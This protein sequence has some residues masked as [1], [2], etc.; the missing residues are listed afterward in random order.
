MKTIANAGEDPRKQDH[1]PVLFR[2][3]GGESI[4]LG[5]IMRCLAVA[6]ALL[7]QGYPCLFAVTALPAPAHRRLEAA[8]VT[9]VAVPGPPGGGGDR[10][11]T[12]ALAARSDAVV[13]DGYDFDPAYRAAVAAAGR[14][15]LAFDDGAFTGEH[16]P[17]LL[18][19][20]MVV[21]PSVGV[22]PRDYAVSAPGAGL[23]LGASHAPLRRE[24]RQAAALPPRSL[25]DRTAVLLTFG[26]S[27]PLGLTVPCLERLAPALPDGVRLLTVVGGGNPR[28][29]A[30]R[31]AAAAWGNRVE[32][33]HD[34]PVMGALMARSGLAVAAAGGTTAELAALAVPSLLVV[35]ADNQA[36]A[37]TAAGVLPWCRIVDARGGGDAAADRVAEAALTLWHAPAVRAAMAVAAR[38]QVDGEGAGRI[39]QALRD[40]MAAAVVPAGVVPV[41]RTVG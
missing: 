16:P 33:H 5:H 30:C 27:D 20:R 29:D 40:A 28:L 8:G 37:A 38:G 36:P 19:A 14:P 34:T 35:V 31:A 23:L 9:V 25:S 7:D 39:A 24:I 6:E 41:P 15:I 12:R 21:N 22:V 32:L 10:E 18:S 1:F 26:G 2:A 11:A 3:D 13:L 4:G 17:G